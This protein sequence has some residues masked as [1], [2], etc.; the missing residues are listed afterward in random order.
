MR[1]VVESCANGPDL[2]QVDAATRAKPEPAKDG[3]TRRQDR[4]G[5][6]RPHDGAAVGESGVGHGELQR[7]HGKVALTDCEVDRIS[8]VPDALRRR[9]ERRSQPAW[10]GDDAAVFAGDIQ[11][12]RPAEAEL[13]CPALHVQGPGRRLSCVEHRAQSVEPGVAGNG[14]RLVEVQVGVDRRLDVVEDDVPDGQGAG[15][16]QGR[17]R[18]DQSRRE[19]GL[20]DDRLEGRTGRIEALRRAVQQR[21]ASCMEERAEVAA[22][23]RCPALVEPGVAGQGVDLAVPRVHHDCRAR[24]GV[25]VAGPMCGGD[26][27][28]DCTYGRPLQAQ[29][30]RQLQAAGSRRARR[31]S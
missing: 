23:D 24:V 14:E 11:T 30:D 22:I 28:S 7:R 10:S 18:G 27:I 17:P 20:G 25:R 16:G 2:G 29:V 21:T 13:V 5:D 12:R 4:A 26:P 6:V 9:A 19:R 31:C 1:G 8:L 3:S 15:A